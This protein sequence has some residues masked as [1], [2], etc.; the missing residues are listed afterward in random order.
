MCSA[1]IEGYR[2]PVCFCNTTRSRSPLHCRNLLLHPTPYTTLHRT[3]HFTTHN[4]LHPTE[5]RPTPHFTP[6]HILHTSPQ[7]PTLTVQHH[8]HRLAPPHTSLHS[9]PH[10][11]RSPAQHQTSP[12][13]TSPLTL[14][15]PQF[16]PHC[17]RLYTRRHPTRHYAL[18][19]ITRN[20]ALRPTPCTT[21]HIHR[22]PQHTNLV[23]GNPNC[24]I[25]HPTSYTRHHTSPWFHPHPYT[26]HTPCT[27][28]HFTSGG[29]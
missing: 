2:P 27:P 1:V 23:H 25:L 9:T 8:T 13:A 28:P 12:R 29:T 16:T 11:A 18:P 20:I 15:T 14:P 5:H 7:N 10:P 3:P 6:H 21:R 19:C 26:P 17:T 24:T 22:T 4:I